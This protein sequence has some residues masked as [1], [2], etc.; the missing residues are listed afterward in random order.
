MD[1]VSSLTVIAA[2]S[3]FS[4][5]I[6]VGL[7]SF[8]SSYGE[9]NIAKEAVH[10]ISVQPD[11]APTII[12]TLFISMAMVESSA[13]YCLVIAMILVF[14]NPFWNTLVEKL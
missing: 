13:I 12:K 8:G 10:S 6:V 7:G 5:A 1:I 4:A 11:E 3:S 2:V 14:A 9:A